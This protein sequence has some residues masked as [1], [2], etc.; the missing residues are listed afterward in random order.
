M[1]IFFTTR[2]HEFSDHYN[3]AS[4]VLLHANSPRVREAGNKLLA[5]AKMASRF[6]VGIREGD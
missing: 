1:Y 2:C 6:D 3:A 5:C 4:S